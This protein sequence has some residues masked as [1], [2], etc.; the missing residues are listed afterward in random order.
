MVKITKYALLNSLAV[1]AYIVL[2]ANFMFFM[3]GRGP[4]D[5]GATI[6]MPITFLM[7]LVFSV[8]FVGTMLFGKPLMWYIDGKKKDALNLLVWTLGIFFVLVVLVL[9][10]LFGAI[11]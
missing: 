10:L 5:D 11:L 6:W 4:I 2:I 8:A 1:V 7:L 3:E 9:I